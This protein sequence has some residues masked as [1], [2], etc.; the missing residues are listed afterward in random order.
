AEEPGLMCHERAMPDVHNSEQ[1]SFN[2]SRV[3]S[4]G[5][6]TTEGNFVRILK[7]SRITGWRRR[8]RIVGH[9]D[10]VFPRIRVVIFLDGC[11]WHQC[12][13]KCKP[14]PKNNEFWIKK[15][16]ANASRDRIVT[17]RLQRSRWLVLR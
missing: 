12:P 11:F 10:F 1:R 8:Y 9:P 13:R 17:R 6:R 15:L 16:S 3:R 4:H 5:N 2:M 7:R 14:A